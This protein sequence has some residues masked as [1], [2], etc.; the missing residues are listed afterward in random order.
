M[1]TLL[2]RRIAILITITSS[3]LAYAL[4]FSTPVLNGVTLIALIVLAAGAYVAHRIQC[5]LPAKEAHVELAASSATIQ[6][7]HHQQAA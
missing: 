2:R 5:P 7:S 6:S 4:G 3:V 1:T